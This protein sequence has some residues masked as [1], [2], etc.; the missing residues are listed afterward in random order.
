MADMM[1][2]A[3]LRAAAK[4][5]KPSPKPKPVDGGKPMP[6]GYVPSKKR[7]S[8]PWGSV[9]ANDPYVKNQSDF[10]KKQAQMNKKNGGY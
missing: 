2:V 7:K 3:V 5:P 6:K 8:Y 1:S 10:L 4:K 9:P